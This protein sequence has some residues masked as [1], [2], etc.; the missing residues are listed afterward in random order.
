MKLIPKNWSSFQH[1]KL[2]NPPWIKLHKNLLDDMN[3]QRLPL[4]SK[5][6]A[7][8]L[9][10]LASESNSGEINKTTEEIAFRL[11][12]TEKEV[13]T[14]IKP[15]LDMGFFIDASKMLANGLQDAMSETET[16]TETETEI[17]TEKPN[18]AESKIP[19]C[20]HQQ[21]IDIYH[22]ILPE[23]PKVVAWN[24]T[25]ESH[26]KQ[27]WRELFVEYECKSTEEGLD[28]FKNDFFQ[29]VKNSRFLTGKVSSNGRRAFLANLPWVI[30]PENFAKIIERKYE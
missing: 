3:F 28:W 11:R 21:I 9:W 25:R 30:K 22:Q 4:A 17:E 12:M 10:L 20:P 7:P 6:I 19:P 5:A 15:L 13:S 14:A 23:L 27:R 8:M 1:Y 2:R 26:L 24:K 18:Y 16:E 29:F